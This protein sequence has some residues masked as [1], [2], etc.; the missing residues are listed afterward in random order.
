[1][2]GRLDNLAALRAE[3]ERQQAA[4]RKGFVS[5][6]GG[7]PQL[8]ERMAEAYRRQAQADAVELELRIEAA[9]RRASA[10]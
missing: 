3:I 2:G 4:I 6:E 9:V 5:V 8:R 1:M 10:P 7:E